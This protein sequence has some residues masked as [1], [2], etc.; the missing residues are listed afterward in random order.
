MKYKQ[1]YNKHFAIVDHYDNELVTFNHAC[2]DG[3]W[4]L[5]IRNNL[6]GA[7]ETREYKTESALTAAITKKVN[8]FFRIYHK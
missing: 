1:R 5:T 7:T 4:Y 8:R 2:F 3:V 6:T